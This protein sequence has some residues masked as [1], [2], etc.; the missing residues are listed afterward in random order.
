M[1]NI[2]DILLNITEQFKN[3]N[4]WLTNA[5]FVNKVSNYVIDDVGTYAGISDN[6]NTYLYIRLLEG[7]DFNPPEKFYSSCSGNGGV[8]EY[9]LQAPCRLVALCYKANKFKLEQVVRET[10]C[11]LNLSN[12]NVK[13]LTIELRHSILN[14][15]QVFNIEFDTNTYKHRDNLTIISIDFILKYNVIVDN[16]CPVINLCDLDCE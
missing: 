3:L 5:K 12:F 4:N 13:N 16:C 6:K 14:S 7:L 11:R 2:Q 15:E 1:I 9:E 10:F 8:C